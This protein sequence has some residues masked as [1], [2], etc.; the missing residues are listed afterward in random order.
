[1]SSLVSRTVILSNY[2]CGLD[3]DRSDKQLTVRSQ[4]PFNAEAPLESLA[5]HDV[6]PISN[7][8]VRNHLPVPDIDP[9]LYELKICGEGISERVFSLADL[10]SLPKFTVRYVHDQTLQ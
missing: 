1:M 7:F 3:P 8:F 6:T 5:D 10:K 9:D 4:Q 2:A